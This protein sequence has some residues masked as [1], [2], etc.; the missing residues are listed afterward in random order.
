MEMYPNPMMDNIYH[1]PQARKRA[2][3]A[4]GKPLGM[5]YFIMQPKMTNVYSPEEALRHGTLFPELFMPF[6]GKRGVM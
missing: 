6:S 1:G 5:A 4:Y 3:A 2:D